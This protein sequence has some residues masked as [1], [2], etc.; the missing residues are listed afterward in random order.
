MII[1]S[2]NLKAVQAIQGN[3][4]KVLNFALVRRIQHSLV[5]VAYRTI[6]HVFRKDNKEA[7][8]LAKMIVGNEGGLLLY[9]TPL[10]GFGY[11]FKYLLVIVFIHHKI[12][13][14]TLY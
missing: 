5:K 6:H 11:F 13:S 7:D 9:N 2:N 14:F 3:F 4:T 12:V 1:L 8:S 10:S